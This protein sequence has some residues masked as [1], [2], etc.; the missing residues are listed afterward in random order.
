MQKILVSKLENFTT[1]KSTEAKAVLW[2]FFYFFFLLCSYYIIRPIRDEMGVI[3]GVDNLQWLFTATFF[4]M[5]ALVPVFGWISSR[6]VRR[7]FL[8]YVY[9]FFI[10]NL[11]L[12]YFVIETGAISQ[13]VARIFFVWVSVFNLFVVSVFWS[14]MTDV[15]SSEQSKR[16]FALIASGGTVGA[17]TGPAITAVLST[18]LGIHNLLLLS[19]I[20]LFAAVICIKQIIR[21]FDKNSNIEDKSSDGQRRFENDVPIGGGVFS[22]VTLVLKSRYLLGICLLMLLFT[23]LATFLYFQQ[24]KI[25]SSFTADSG[26]RTSIFAI[27]DLSVNVLTLFLQLFITGRIIKHIGLAWTLT[28]IPVLLAAGF[29]VLAISPVISVLIIVQVLRRAGNYAVMRPAREMLYVVLD[30]ETKYKAKNFI[31]TTVYRA[32]DAVSSW[33][34]TGFSMLG[35]S[36]SAIAFI[37]VPISIVW[38]WIAYRLGKYRENILTTRN[39]TL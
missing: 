16:L 31:D 7:R 34:Y 24:A 30:K 4:A 35:L 26:E 2:S 29:F 3:G 37:A 39:R 19:A 22:G 10:F 15:Y 6:F 25:I 27:I 21:W 20:F 5:L 8:P 13:Y 14:F 36:L 33:V 12:F 32:G 38:A 9:Y 11:F 18:K 28:I 23:T 1:I 17:I